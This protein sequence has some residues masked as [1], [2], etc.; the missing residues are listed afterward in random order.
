MDKK[1]LTA[2]L[3]LLIQ[4]DKYS[5]LI[6]EITDIIE[7]WD[8][9]PMAYDGD[10]KVLNSLIAV[11]LENRAAFENLVTLIENRRKLIPTLK[12]VDYQRTL[13]QERRARLAKALELHEATV[14]PFKTPADRARVAEDI[15][16]RWAEAR[17]KFVQAKGKLS[18][19]QRNLAVNEF[20]AGI[21][22]KL[23][24]NLKSIRR[25]GVTNSYGVAAPC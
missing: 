21:D 12:R 8:T 19:K 22:A 15:T 13:M 24:A 2:A 25:G 7:R 18:W 5:M 3:N 17:K 6:K 11:G 23:D 14:R 10:L 9:H 20:W 16:T 1:E 4:S